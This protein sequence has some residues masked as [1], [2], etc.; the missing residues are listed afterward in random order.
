MGADAV[1][2]PGQL[3]GARLQAR[4]GLVDHARD[5]H[6][7][8]ERRRQARVQPGQ[9]SLTQHGVDRGHGG[10]PHLDADLA[11]AGVR[12]GKVDGVEDLRTAVGVQC[13][14]AHAVLVSQLQVAD[15]S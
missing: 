11:G 15:S 2:K 4:P 13:D 14:C 12:V 10:R 6:A 8:H 9:Q 5:F 7:G 3:A 1:D